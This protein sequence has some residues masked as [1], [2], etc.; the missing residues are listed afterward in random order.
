MPFFLISAHNAGDQP[1]I[2][3]FAQHIHPVCR[4]PGEKS[5]VDVYMEHIF[6]HCHRNWKIRHFCVS[7]L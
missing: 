2:L 3:F 6:S 4:G 5:A 7:T 1:D